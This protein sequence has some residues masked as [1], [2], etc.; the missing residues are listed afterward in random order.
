VAFWLEENE[1]WRAK[2]NFKV[3]KAKSVVQLE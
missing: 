2:E 3:K 1:E